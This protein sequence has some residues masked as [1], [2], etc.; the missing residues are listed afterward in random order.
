MSVATLLQMF[1][2]SLDI[3]YPRVNQTVESLGYRN[4][5]YWNDT[6]LIPDG[7]EMP[8]QNPAGD[9]SA[10]QLVTPNPE[11]P[12]SRDPNSIYIYAAGICVLASIVASVSFLNFRKKLKL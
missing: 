2:P 3:V 7:P 8:P 4:I 12:S 9:E 1:G 6:R 10:W 5:I 11:N